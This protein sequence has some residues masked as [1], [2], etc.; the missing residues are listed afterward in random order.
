VK[1]ESLESFQSVWGFLRKQYECLTESNRRIGKLGQGAGLTF[2]LQPLLMA[3]VDSTGT[4]LDLAPRP[5]GRDC[6]VLARMV[7]ET[8]INVGFICSEGPSAMDRAE[9]HLVQKAYRDLER[10]FSV[11][12]TVIKQ[13]WSDCVDLSESP[14][15]RQALNEFTT[16]KNREITSWT[17]ESIAERL[18]II[19]RKYGKSI[20]TPL[21]FAFFSLYRYSSEVAHGTL[22]GAMYIYGMTRPNPPKTFEERQDAIRGHLIELML[23]LG[24][25]LEALLTVLASQSKEIEDLAQTA[26]TNFSDFRKAWTLDDGI[27][28]ANSVSE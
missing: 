13:S 1:F 20:S 27:G 25:S 19:D 5:K 3:V 21:A 11:N 15:L 9:R 7:I 4:I 6:L 23:M 24:A 18:E 10:E 14:Y 22:F 2:Q 12:E 26:A 17:P 16:K 8:T 28:T